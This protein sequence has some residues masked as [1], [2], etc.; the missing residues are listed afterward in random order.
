MFKKKLPTSYRNT[1]V[2]HYF[3][4]TF[5]FFRR[6]S[7]I[8]VILLY[9][10]GMPNPAGP[11]VHGPGPAGPGPAVPLVPSPGPRSG[12]GPKPTKPEAHRCGLAVPGPNPLD[13][14]DPE[15]CTC[16]LEIENPIDIH[17]SEA[18]N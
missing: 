15:E 16:L 7:L 2:L 8:F 5:V 10:F 9:L 3:H 13:A 17:G 12:A 1:L 11:L 18:R 4:R 14:D 6:R